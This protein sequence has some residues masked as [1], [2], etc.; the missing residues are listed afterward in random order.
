MKKFLAISLL[1]VTSASI[2]QSKLPLKELGETYG[3]L[4]LQWVITEH[5]AI[6]GRISAETAAFGKQELRQSIK[7]YELDQDIFF[8]IY[9]VEFKKKLARKIDFKLCNQV[10]MEIEDLRLRQGAVA[11]EAQAQAELAQ[12]LRL[13]AQAKVQLEQQQRREA[14]AQ[15]QIEARRQQQ[16]V[17]AN[18]AYR[19]R[20]MEGITQQLNQMGEQ[21]RAF[22]NSVQ[23][24]T[25]NCTRTMMGANCT[26]Y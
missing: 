5:C 24:R 1:L 15:A 10:A 25:T 3:R 21:F 2:A 18:A 19:R 7:K 22:G 12:Q 20:E 23:P 14:Q 6:E 11:A 13:E 17:E 9:V 8:D 16:E 4:G 26:S